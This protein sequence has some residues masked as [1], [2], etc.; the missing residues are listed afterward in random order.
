MRG[1]ASGQVWRSLVSLTTSWLLAGRD[2]DSSLAR[3]MVA[4]TQHGRPVRFRWLANTPPS[5]QVIDL[6]GPGGKLTDSLRFD[7]AGEAL[8]ALDVGRYR[9]RLGRGGSG[10][11]AVEPYSDELVPAA[12][13][14]A[15]REA[16]GS[17]ATPRRSW[18]GVW[19]LFAIAVAGFGAE[20]LLR[21]TLGAT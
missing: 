9:Y 19:W 7:G 1:G 16:T 2:A 13:T 20:W 4:V 5:T 17:P 12:V 15:A 10:S 14:L 8:L 18:R 11:L 21:R 3:P 6:E